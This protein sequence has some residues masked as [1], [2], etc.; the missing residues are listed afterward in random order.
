MPGNRPPCD[1]TA[2]PGRPIEPR[3][4]IEPRGRF[5]IGEPCSVRPADDTTAARPGTD[6]PTIPEP[7]FKILPKK[8]FVSA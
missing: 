1:R 5:P 4:P 2:E 7:R 8:I 6:R 3:P